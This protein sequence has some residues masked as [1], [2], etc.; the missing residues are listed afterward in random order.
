MM[1]MKFLAHL[2]N[3]C[4]GQTVF[5]EAFV[6]MIDSLPFT[7]TYIPTYRA[8]TLVPC[9]EVVPLFHFVTTVS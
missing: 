3:Y 9:Y 6:G 1:C 8:T 2:A 7:Y 5:F 4:V